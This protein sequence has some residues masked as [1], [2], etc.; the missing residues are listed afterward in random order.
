MVPDGASLLDARLRSDETAA[1]EWRERQKL[2]DDPRVTRI[3]RVLRRSSLDELPQLWN[4]L[5]GDMSLVGPRPIVASEVARYCRAYRY[6][7][8]VRPG[9]TGLWQIRGRGE[10]SY[11]ARVACDRRYIAR[12]SVTGDVAIILLTVPAVLSGRGSS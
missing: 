2:R 9:L 5:R 12:W 8:A 4:V 11:G 10:M 6:Y 1:R 7:T 3:G